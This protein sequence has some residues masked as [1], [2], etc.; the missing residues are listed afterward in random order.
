MND[1]RNH[2]R[3]GKVRWKRAALLMVPSLTAAA[4][5][6]TL[7]MRGSIAANFT[8]AGDEFKISADRLDGAG[9]VQ[10]TGLDKDSK[11][12]SEHVLITGIRSAEMRNMCASM[13]ADTPAGPITLLLRSGRDTPVRAT[14][15][16]I[17]LTRMETGATFEGLALGRDAAS[18]SGGPNDVLGAPGQYG[19]QAKRLQLTGFRLQTQAVTAGNFMFA[20]LKIAVKPGRHECF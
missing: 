10:F 11:G 3:C 5:L 14:S 1:A 15:L 17:D 16:V 2:G 13:L 18:L 9:L 8:I 6:V 12:R 20:G 19:Q 4:A 7:T